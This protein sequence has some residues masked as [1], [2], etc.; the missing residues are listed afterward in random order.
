MTPGTVHRLFQPI[1]FRVA[2]LFACCLPSFIG[3]ALLLPGVGAV[4]QGSSKSYD[5]VVAGAGTG[6]FSAAIQA[7]RLGARVALLEETDWIGGQMAAAAVS[8]MDEG[9]NLTPPSGIY[10]EFLT[11][12]GAYYLARG[13]SVGTC[14]WSSGGHCFEPS[15]IRKILNGMITEVNNTPDG[16]GHIDLILEDR[17]ARVTTTGKTVTGVITAHGRTLQSKVLIDATEFGDVIPLTPARFRSGR[18]VGPDNG[19]SC[20]QDLT[21]TMVIKKYPNG[22][23]QELR[24]QHTPPEY[25]KWLPLLQ[26][27]WQ[28]DGNPWVDAVPV[29]FANHNAYRGLPDSSNPDSYVSA[30]T[31]KITRTVLNWFNDLPTHTDIFD[32]DARKKILCEAK[33]KTLA[34]LYYLQHELHEPL[35]SVANDEGYDTPF[36]RTENSCP[37]IPEEFKVIEA[38][39][40]ALPYIRESQRVIGEYTLTAGDIRRERQGGISVVGFA[41]S[42]AVGDYPDDLHACDAESD[43]EEQL[44]HL[45]DRPRGFRSGPF[46]V[47]LRSL[48][49]QEVDGFLV[50]E[51]NI[52]QSRLA[53]SATR[54]QPITMLTGQAAG[55]LAA[56]AVR[57]GIQPAAV[58]T[59]QVQTVLLQSG[60]IIARSPMPD[61]TMGTRS[62]QAAQF[63][64]AHKWMDLKA[65]GFAPQDGLT[66]GEAAEILDRAFQ[67]SGGGATSPA[68][69]CRKLSCTKASYTDLPLYSNFSAA[70]EAWHALS[71]VPPCK[72]SPALFCP[73]ASLTAKE[74]VDSLVAIGKI[75]RNVNYDRAALLKDIDGKEDD[76]IRR[77]DVALVLYNSQQQLSFH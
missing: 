59:G 58:P 66:R 42:I 52:S 68:T 2:M 51:K 21:Y 54:L 45:S 23:S 63:A 38:N 64:V 1:V 74:F 15:A 22:V 47:P 70:V 29:N 17:V 5:V 31:R 3:I 36:N 48:I 46:E 12:M 49:A 39:M 25:E 16:R 32:R 9:N 62:W 69:I 67:L 41:D 76:P 10:R 33:L 44:E 26:A 53:N 8:T 20:T 56:L 14:Y 27:K 6:G 37:N 57:E 75:K 50:A 7:A 43:L 28:V 24:M 35:W 65:A 61:M 77:A 71:P 19:K 72:Q 55:T 4:A 13:K 60:S 34:N 11:R 73:N 18:S 30:E 40:P